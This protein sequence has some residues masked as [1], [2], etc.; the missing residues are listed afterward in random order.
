MMM[1]YIKDEGGVIW[2]FMCGWGPFGYSG[3]EV[4]QVLFCLSG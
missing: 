4:D 2:L 1:R 3:R